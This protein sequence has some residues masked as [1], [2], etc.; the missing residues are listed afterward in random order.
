MTTELPAN[1]AAAVAIGARHFNGSPCKRGHA[2]LRYT[3]GRNCVE[4]V[5]IARGG[6]QKSR[7]RSTDNMTL[8]LEAQSSGRT[9]YNANRPCPHGHYERYVTSNNCVECNRLAFQRDKVRNKFTRIRSEYGL[10]RETYLA[11]VLGQQSSCRICGRLCRAVTK[12]ATNSTNS[13]FT[14]ITAMTAAA[15]V[16]CFA[17]LAIRGSASSGIPRSGCVSP[18]CTSAARHNENAFTPVSIY[19]GKRCVFLLRARNGKPVG[20]AA[21]R[22]RKVGRAC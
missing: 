5:R 16:G 11:M 19:R 21:D 20:G 4:C 3:S 8:A 15:C 2:G 6:W 17:G 9:T 22:H 14:S 7:R 12:Q 18:S 10:D 1:H 13:S